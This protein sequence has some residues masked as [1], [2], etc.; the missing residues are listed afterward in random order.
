[1]TPA[2]AVAELSM[3]QVEEIHT[4]HL[5]NL[6]P[7]IAGYVG[8][9]KIELDGEF[10]SAQLRAIATWMENPMQVGKAAHVD[11]SDPR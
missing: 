6:S 3:M 5:T 8:T 9:I 4:S 2:E 11:I 7:F 10:T 1:M